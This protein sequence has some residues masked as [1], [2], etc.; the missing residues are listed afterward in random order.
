MRAER[1]RATVCLLP[2]AAWAQTAAAVAPRIHDYRRQTLGPGHEIRS[3][4]AQGPGRYEVEGVGK[5][6]R[7]GD[8]LRFTLKGSE[9][10]ELVLDVMEL[11]EKLIPQHGWTAVLSG[12]DFDS[13]DIHRWSIV[14]DACARKMDFEFCAPNGAPQDK[15]LVQAAA[16]VEDLDWT[17]KHDAHLCD[18]CSKG[19]P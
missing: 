8:R 9:T 7:E 3:F 14:C 2:R 17:T 16:R 15:L 12:A 4:E 1:A 11:R 10:L 18:L 19:T 13:L 6:V 5:H